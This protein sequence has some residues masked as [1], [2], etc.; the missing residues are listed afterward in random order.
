MFDRQRY[1]GLRAYLPILDK[2]ISLYVT[3]LDARWTYGRIDVLVCPAFARS[4][5][6]SAWVRLASLAGE[7]GVAIEEIEHHDCEAWRDN[8]DRC[9]RC[10]K[11]VR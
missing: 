2:Q 1:V 8:Q 10:G 11:A 7:D 4:G 6:G 9:H 5:T 3:I